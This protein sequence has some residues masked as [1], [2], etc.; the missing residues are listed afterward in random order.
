ML[1]INI[2]LCHGYMFPWEFLCQQLAQTLRDSR[3][4]SLCLEHGRFEDP[5]NL[6]LS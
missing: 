5:S 6:V 2:F 1:Q 4:S 3:W